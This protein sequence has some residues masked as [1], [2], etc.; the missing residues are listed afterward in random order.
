MV[1][2][3]GKARLDTTP[4]AHRMDSI[5]SHLGMWRICTCSAARIQ[6][7]RQRSEWPQTFR[8]RGEGR[9]RTPQNA[10]MAASRLETL[11]A[12]L[13]ATAEAADAEP[14]GVASSFTSVPC[15]ASA[16]DDVVIVSALRTPIC[17]AKRGDFKDT[18]PDLLLMSVLKATMDRTKVD[19]SRVG[20]I[21]VGNVLQPGAGAVTARMAQLVCG[22][23]F[24]VPLSVVNRQCSSGLQ[25]RFLHVISIESC[26]C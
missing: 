1:G 5:C 23:P 15:A 12:H 9:R 18:P 8:R 26:G 20:D 19:P 24:T 10:H 11:K 4:R 2:P 16:A 13:A 17:K 3:Y 25:V 22:I 6:P 21:V 7:Q 14:V